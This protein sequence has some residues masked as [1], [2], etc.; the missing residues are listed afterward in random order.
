M[1]PVSRRFHP[2]FRLALAGAAMGVAL[3]AGP[4]MAQGVCDTGRKLFEDRQQLIGQINSWGKKKVDPNVAC[5]TFTKL[6]ANGTA[7]IKFMGENGSWCR[8]PPEAVAAM[9]AQQKQVATSRGQACK[10]AADY[11]KAL[12]QAE[13]AKRANEN[14]IFAAPDDVTGGPRR[15]PSGAL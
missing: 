9:E 7:V 15:V 11:Q 3:T 2:V 13:Q 12:R 14:N 10:V 5:S 8:I 6:Q 1:V 4:A